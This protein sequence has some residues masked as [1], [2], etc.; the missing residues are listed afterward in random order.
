MEG[1]EHIQGLEH[2]QRER[3]LSNVGIFHL[4]WDSNRNDAMLP[5]GKQQGQLPA[6]DRGYASRVELIRIAAP[7]TAARARR[8]TQA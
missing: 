4:Y 2:H 7:P 6:R 8:A 5:L 1:P 3:A